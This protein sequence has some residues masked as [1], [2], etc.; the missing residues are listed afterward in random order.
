MIE[1]I[2]VVT[3]PP[4]SDEVLKQLIPNLTTQNL[5]KF[6]PCFPNS[7]IQSGEFPMNTPINFIFYVYWKNLDERIGANS[8][9]NVAYTVTLVDQIIPEIKASSN[10]ADVESTLIFD[11]SESKFALT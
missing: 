6:E 11:A 5:Q 8:Y 1:E 4:L 2:T 10:P 7:L 3:Q 9:M